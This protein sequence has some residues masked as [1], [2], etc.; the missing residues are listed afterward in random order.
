M[1][2]YSEIENT[3]AHILFKYGALMIISLFLLRKI[4]VGLNVF[5]SILISVVAILYYHEKRELNMTGLEKQHKLKGDTVIPDIKN[6]KKYKE[7]V[8]FLFSIQDFFSYNPESYEEM[9]DNLI[10]FFTMYEEVEHGVS[11]CEDYYGIAKSKK[12]NALNCLHSLIYNVPVTQ[13]T[14][15]KLIKAQKVLEEMLNKYLDKIA[16]ACKLSLRTIG[17]TKDRNIINTGPYPYNEYLNTL[18]YSFDIN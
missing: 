4:S 10:A 3:S 2:L 13:I 1:G 8:D 5:L 6:V 14:S 17:Y 16:D 15:Q 11:R 7:I 9:I 12:K 18:K